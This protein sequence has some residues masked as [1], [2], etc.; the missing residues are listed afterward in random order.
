LKG[1]KMQYLK[2]QILQAHEKD[3]KNRTFDFS[4]EKF[5]SLHQ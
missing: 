5:F 2:L 1:E 4:L 3:K